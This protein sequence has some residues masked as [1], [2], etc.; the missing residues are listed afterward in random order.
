VLFHHPLPFGGSHMV[1]DPFM[2]NTAGLSA[3][4][5]RLIP[6]EKFRRKDFTL[7]QALVIFPLYTPMINVSNKD[8][9]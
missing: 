1:Y 4:S 5:S 8:T 7:N 6:I 3:H 2:Q 9:G